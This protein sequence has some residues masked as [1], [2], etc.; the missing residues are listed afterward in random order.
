M[1]LTTR[2]TRLVENHAESL[3]LRWAQEV[4]TNPLTSSYSVF[5]KKE[6][7]DIVFSRFRRLGQWIEKREGLEKEIAQS[8]CEIGRMRATSGIR[9]SEM[10]YS[11]MLEKDLVWNY[12]QD[13]GIITEGIDMN[14][15]LQFVSQLD[16]F[17]DK[18]VYFALVGYENAG[19][20]EAVV[21]EEGAF[22]KTFEG[23]K[24]WII[25]E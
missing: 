7:H 16:Y 1:L 6:L 12:I 25:R 2:F 22:E 20:D 18:A 15:A 21:K 23:F 3:S 13:E 11:L 14:R 4:R 17:Y 5:S 10:V 19:V 24:H 9:A 8:F